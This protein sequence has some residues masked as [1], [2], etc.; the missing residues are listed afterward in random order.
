MSDAFS[1]RWKLDRPHLPQMQAEDVYVLLTIE[2]NAAR[3]TSGPGLPVHLILLVDVSGSMDILM[4]HDPGAEPVGDGLTEGRVSQKVMSDVPSRREMA[5]TVVQKLAE[6]LTNEDLLTVVAFDDKAH[7]LAAGVSPTALDPLWSAIRRLGEVGGGGTAMGQGLDAVRQVL[8]SISDPGRT[9]KLVVL[10]D[11]EDQHPSQA[12]AEAQALC[13]EF[14]VPITAFGTGECKVAFLTDVAKT[15]L[16]G[17]FNHIRGEGDASQ[18]FHHVLTGQKNVQATNVLLK[19][20]LA[21]EI[22]VRELYRTRPEILYVGDLQ[23]DAQNLV[24]LRLEQMEG[25]KAYEFLFRCTVP[26]R[27]AEQRL[28]LAKATLAFDLPGLGLPGQTDGTNIGLEFTADDQRARERSGDV[29][30]V[31]ARAE[32]QRQVLFV[33]QKADLF[34]Q[35][36]GTDQDRL[37]VA[38]VLKALV[39]KFTDFGDQAMANQ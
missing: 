11:G 37:I 21:P 30:R 14:S 12:L 18:F 36:L 13:R 9:R 20:W 1:L 29:R 38:R 31:L 23:P 3:V 10:T 2:P 25:G 15:T 33:Q 22:H 27:Q 26:P 39:Q 17:S 28:R 32:V 7:V 6:R 4:R 5:C 35:G 8:T 34:N 16:A 19:L 24:E